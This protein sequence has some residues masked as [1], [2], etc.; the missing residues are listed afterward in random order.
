MATYL[1][2]Q[3]QSDNRLIEVVLPEVHDAYSDKKRLRTLF[4]CEKF[5]FH[6]GQ[7]TLITHVHN[8]F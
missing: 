7:P 2:L 4:A 8:S 6:S 3:L 1:Q 5:Y